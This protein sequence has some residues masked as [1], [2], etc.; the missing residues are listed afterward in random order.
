MSYASSKSRKTPAGPNES[1]S[2]EKPVK[3][4]AGA[5]SSPST[6]EDED[7]T[8]PDITAE[9]SKLSLDKTAATGSTWETFQML[10]AISLLQTYLPMAF[11]CRDSLIHPQS[12]SDKR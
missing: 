4:K 3:G 10:Y 8:V 9:L 1:S 7:A 11:T 5:A 2:N 6:W 12:Q